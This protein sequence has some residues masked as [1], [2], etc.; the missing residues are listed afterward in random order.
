MPRCSQQPAPFRTNQALQ[1]CYIRLY[2]Q[3]ILL[4]LHQISNIS[5]V[6]IRNTI[7]LHFKQ[8]TQFAD[9]GYLLGSKVILIYKTP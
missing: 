4:L 6:N 7:E 2:V 9:F 5:L 1:I 3:N 8:F